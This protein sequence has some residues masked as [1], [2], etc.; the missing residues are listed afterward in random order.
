M[1][2]LTRS[3][4]FRW[5]LGI[6][7]WSTLLSLMLF[8]FVY[9]QTAAFMQDELNQVL[10]HEVRYAARDPGQAANRIETWISED[11]HSV[12]FAGLFGPDGKKLAGNLDARPANLSLDG[13]VRRIGTEVAIAGRRLHE[14]LW[15]AA[16]ALGDGT[17]V[18]VAHDTDEIDRAKSTVIRALGLALV[19]TLAFSILGGVLLAGRAKR[20]LAST[21]AAVARVMRGDLRQRLPV[22]DA[23]DE[24]DRLARDV[25]GMLDEIER[26]MDEVRSVGDAVAHDLRTPLTRLRLRLERGRDQAR[27]IGE[28]REAVDQ[29]LVWIDQTLEMVTAVLRIGEI[30]HGRRCAAFGPVDL[31][32]V[33]SEAAELFE[34]LAEDKGIDLEATVDAGVPAIEGDRSLIFEAI[35]NLLDN[36]IKFTPA[37]G[38]VRLGLDRRDGDGDAVISVEDTGPGIVAGERD[39]VFKRFYRAE[40]ARQTQG[41]GL[42]LGLVAAIAKLHGFSLTVGDGR[43]GGC[44]FEMECPV[45]DRRSTITE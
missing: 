19:P 3:F 16:V 35:S 27:D 28:L 41:N 30:E 29:G 32:L 5:A 40:R 9:W 10:R 44:R 45:A 12:H 38:S 8:A 24:F 31:G 26:L 21:E 13:E 6:A 1:S 36:A 42:G 23:G 33:V 20:R 34:P 15:S 18:V 43:A 37:G 14:D 39:Q 2:R 7:L 4:A 22:G 17:V 11:L 25:N